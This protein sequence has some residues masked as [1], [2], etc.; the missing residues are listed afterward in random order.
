MITYYLSLII[1]G[2]V[3]ALVFPLTYLPDASLPIWMTSGL[4]S[5]SETFANLYQILPFTVSVIVSAVSFAI[6]VSVIT[7]TYKSIRGGVS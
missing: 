2:F 3:K 1:L 6:T 5:A 7:L 4:S